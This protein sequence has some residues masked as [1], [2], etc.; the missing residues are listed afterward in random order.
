MFTLTTVKGPVV[1]V[2]L[3]GSPTISSPVGMYEGLS[4]GTRRAAYKYVYAELQPSPSIAPTTVWLRAV[5]KGVCDAVAWSWA[6]M[7][8]QFVLG[9]TD[10]DCATPTATTTTTTNQHHHQHHNA[11][12][13]GEC[14]SNADCN[15]S[16]DDDDTVAGHVLSANEDRARMRTCMVRGAPQRRC[17]GVEIARTT[18]AAA[19]AVLL[20]M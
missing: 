20:P 14:F 12:L 18:L 19:A 9:S 11:D 2:D 17:C 7:L 13:T 1:N 10:V 15:P 3:V 16:D 8:H 4:G 5:Y 6:T